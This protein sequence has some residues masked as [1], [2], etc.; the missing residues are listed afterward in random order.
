MAKP[1]VHEMPTQ[2]MFGE[3]PI[4]AL[5]KLNVFAG[6]TQPR[7]PEICAKQVAYIESAKDK[8]HSTATYDDSADKV[9]TRIVR[10]S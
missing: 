1:A 7:Y 9:Y 2:I 4:A 10:L 3:G 5:I 6:N 8:L